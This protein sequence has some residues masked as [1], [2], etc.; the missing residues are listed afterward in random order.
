MQFTSSRAMLPDPGPKLLP[1]RADKAGPQPSCLQTTWASSMDQLSPHTVPQVLAKHT[2]TRPSH[3]LV[4]FT[5]RRARPGDVC[6]SGCFPSKAEIISLTGKDGAGWDKEA[7]QT[8]PASSWWPQLWASQPL[9]RH[10]HSLAS[11]PMHSTSS[12][13]MGPKPRSKCARPMATT[14]PPQPSCRHT[15]WASLRSQLSSHTV[16]QLPL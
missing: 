12:R 6:T 7:E 14:A 1:G 9:C 10:C 2:S 8:T 11:V 15:T 13:T 5:S 4:P 16:P 3:L